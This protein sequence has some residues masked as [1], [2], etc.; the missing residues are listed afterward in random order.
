MC[1]LYSSSSLAAAAAAD[2]DDILYTVTTRNHPVQLQ[3]SFH[4]FHSC[5]LFVHGSSSVFIGFQESRLVFHGS[6][7]F[8]CFF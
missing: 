6:R 2:D 7:L 4:G 8:L 5:R 1:M 3:V